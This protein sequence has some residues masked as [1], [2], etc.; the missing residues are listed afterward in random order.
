MTGPSRREMLLASGFT[1]L[2]LLT[3]CGHSAAQS[4]DTLVIGFSPEPTTLSSASTTA[5]P[6]QAIST[7]IFDGLVTF[8]AALKPQPQLA[9]AWETASD[10]L[11]LTLHLRSGVRWHDGHPFASADVAFSLLQVWKQYHSR[12][13]STFAPVSAVETPD[14]ATVILRLEAPAPYLLSALGSAESQVVPRHLYE[15]RDVLSNPANLK[16]V[17]TGPFR[18]V[19]WSR[20]QYIT[21]ER[22]PD[23]WDKGRPLLERIIYRMIADPNSASAALEAGEIDLAT[24]TQLPLH[25]V[26]RLG[27]LPGMH[28]HHET[29]GFTAALAVFEF[30]LDR[31]VFHDV[32]VRQAFAHAIDRGFL[33]DHIW[34]GFGAIA[35]SPIPAEMRDFHASGLPDYPFDLARAAALLDAAGLHPDAQ[36]IRM[37]I[38]HD[39]APTGEML[40]R[41]AEYIRDTLKKIGIELQLRRSD[42][43]TF[44]KRIYTERDFDTVQYM[45]SSGPDPAIGTQ[46]FYWSRNFQPGVAFS[47]GSHYRNAE[48]DRLLEAAQR[49]SDPER[50]R[51]LYARFQ[52][53]VQTELPRIPLISGGLVA[54]ARAKVEGYPETAYGFYDDFAGVRIGSG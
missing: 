46:R 12:G 41:A 34:Y 39:P 49:E 24:S 47:N 3:A 53:I 13:R 50:R 31:P 22:N 8:D 7:K 2:A 20:G 38:S 27:Q 32:R 11:S 23:Y 16:P 10:G 54:V 21:L 48:V 42:F 40:V 29:S 17:G 36:G 51:A 1:G 37:R 52:A 19:E 30:N 18:F 26:A 33:R 35:D 9:T 25:D 6:T 5:G 44:V 28:L 14:A 45:A 43:G 4:A 15:G